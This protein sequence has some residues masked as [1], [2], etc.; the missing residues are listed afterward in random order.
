MDK[1]EVRNLHVS[2]NGKEILKGLNL[3]VKPGEMHVIM[4]P[5]GSGKSTLCMALMGHPAYKIM[6]GKILVDGRDVTSSK[7]DK[8]AKAGLFLGF[9][10]PLEIPGVTFG[11][12]LR[13]AV[14]SL[15]KS[16]KTTPLGV[17]EFY[18][19]I[20]GELEKLK[21]DRD[22]IGRGLNDGFSGGEKKRAEIIQMAVLKPKYAILDEIDSGLDIDALKKVASGIN[23]I[24][25]K[26]KMG[27]VLVTHY[28]RILNYLDPDFV[29]VFADGRIIES[30]GPEI[31]KRLEKHGY[32]SL[33]NT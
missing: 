26:S 21:M 17:S 25:R 28:Q 18:P 12:F 7:T 29:H 31:A 14:N 30:G 27:L 13:H 8:R 9:Q 24:F 2:I 33:C 19:L 5:N 20:S 10:Y 22:F 4:G 16:R 23:E 32:E 15:N 1:L 6:N 11:N 3:T